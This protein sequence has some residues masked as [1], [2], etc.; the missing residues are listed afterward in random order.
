MR[1]YLA[2]KSTELG[3]VTVALIGLG[4]SNT[5]LGVANYNSGQTFLD[6]A[7]VDTAL[8]V[9]T[10]QNAPSLLNVTAYFEYMWPRYYAFFSDPLAVNDDLEQF[11]TDA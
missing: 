7:L 8:N 9:V 1:Y 11:L 6:P 3:K 2:G 10:D 5:T 4:M